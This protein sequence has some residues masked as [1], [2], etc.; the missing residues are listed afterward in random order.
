MTRLS[1]RSL[2]AGMVVGTACFRVGVGSATGAA[3]KSQ[4]EIRKAELEWWRQ[5]IARL[6]FE[7]VAVPGA[8]A[9]ETWRRL[10]GAG[11]G[12]PVVVGDEEALGRVAEHYVMDDPA[13]VPNVAHRRPGAA[14][15]IEAAE[16]L[17]MP[18]DLSAWQGEVFGLDGEVLA[19]PEGTW[20]KIP[21]RSAEG[22]SVVRNVRTGGFQ[23]EVFI[24]LVPAAEG[25]DVPAYLK[26]G[27]WNACPPPEY[28]VA[29]LRSWHERFGA[30]L[31]GLG[32]DVMDLMVGRPPGSRE[33]AL[34]LAREEYLYCPDSI[35]QG[36]G[37]VA[38]RAAH[39]MNS[40]WWQLW[41][42]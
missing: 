11:R 23:P 24:L 17:R 9:L 30:E 31:V 28:H 14:E 5:A 33:A 16:R 36:A 26:W 22:P 6:P 1:R 32:F 37:S 20:P 19:P 39:L 21:A 7:R 8:E 10:H 35:D 12:Y 42:D 41:W 4:D 25:Y 13:L 15:V 18:Q 3:V 27:G 2:L 34:A 40:R 38:A 29:V